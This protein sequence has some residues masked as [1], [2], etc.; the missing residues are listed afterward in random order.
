MEFLKQQSEALLNKA[1][2][3][4]PMQYQSN[5]EAPV[6]KKKKSHKK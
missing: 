6:E 4:K 1:D 5:K 3:L 2:S